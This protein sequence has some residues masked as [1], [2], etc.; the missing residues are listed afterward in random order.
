MIIKVKSWGCNRYVSCFCWKTLKIGPQKLTEGKV[1]A[2]H[3]SLHFVSVPFALNNSLSCILSLG[4]QE[5]PPAKLDD[6]HYTRLLLANPEKLELSDHLL[7]L[8]PPQHTYEWDCSIMHTSSPDP[9]SSSYLNLKQMSVTGRWVEMPPFHFLWLPCLCHVN[10]L[11]F[12]ACHHYL[13]ILFGQLGHMA[14]LTYGTRVWS[15]D[16]KSPVFG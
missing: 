4:M 6:S 1:K 14:D 5:G 10:N 9:N 8:C 7:Y 3:S 16:L 13:S 2:R 15:P 11:P 12:F